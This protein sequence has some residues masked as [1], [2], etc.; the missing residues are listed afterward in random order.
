MSF[1][2]FSELPAELQLKIWECSLPG[3]RVI[4]LDLDPGPKDLVAYTSDPTDLNALYLACRDSY[5]AVRKHYVCYLNWLALPVWVDVK[6]DTLYFPAWG[7]TQA[8]MD[9][10]NTTIKHLS[11]GFDMSMVRHMAMN[12]P[13]HESHGVYCLRGFWASYF[14]KAAKNFDLR[15]VTFVSNFVEEL[16]AEFVKKLCR[17]NLERHNQWLISKGFP[18]ETLDIAV[19]DKLDFKVVRHTESLWKYVRR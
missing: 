2:R 10:I 19:L 14:Y 11:L 8:T 3:P 4:E 12:L 9:K 5:N 7:N 13:L 17:A 16:P 6:I 18:G 15:Q 1:S